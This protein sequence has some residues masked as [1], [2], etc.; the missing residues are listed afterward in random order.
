[1]DDGNALDEIW[2]YGLR[3]PQHYS[4]DSDGRMFILDIGQD[5]IE[6]VNIGTAGGNYGWRL[7]EGTF[8]TAYGVTT[9]DRPGGV[10]QRGTDSRTYVYPVAQYDH[11]EGFAIG[12]GFVYRGRDIAALVGKFVFTDL[13]R[14]R[15]FYIDTDA[16]TAGSPTTIYEIPV[17]VDGTGQSL[18]DA[19]GFTNTNSSHLPHN[20]RVDL[21]VS[22]DGRGEMYLLSKG[23]GWIRR[24]VE[25][26]E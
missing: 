20:R 9:S 19:A 7:R 15:L 16:L 3:H 4:W 5:Q 13:V 10:Y 24:L 1:M 11:D 6:E 25:L 12:S 22:V 18:V 17:T 23:D 8:A 14:G 21:R 2:A 26:D